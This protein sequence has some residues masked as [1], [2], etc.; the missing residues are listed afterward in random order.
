MKLYRNMIMEVQKS[1]RYDDNRSNI[2]TKD[3][4]YVVASNSQNSPGE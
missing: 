2:C 3:K 4:G 1:N